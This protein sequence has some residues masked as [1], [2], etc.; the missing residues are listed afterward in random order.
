MFGWHGKR[1][2]SLKKKG[3]LGIQLLEDFSVV[4]QLKQIW[5]FFTNSRSLWVAWVKGNVFLR[6]SFWVMNDSP[7]FSRTIRN[8]LILKPVLVDFLHCKL[9]DG[10]KLRF[11]MV[12]GLI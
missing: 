12:R 4:F 7:H 1:V 6:K 2:V 10:K 3:G 5:N 9:R 8:M 11:G